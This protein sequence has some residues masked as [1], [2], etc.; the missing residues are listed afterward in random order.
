MRTMIR[1]VLVS[2]LL[3]GFTVAAT[4]AAD[5]TL[6]RNNNSYK[7]FETANLEDVM[8][9]LDAGAN[10]MA[11]TK[12]GITPLHWAAKF[13]DD[14][15][16]IEALLEAGADIGAT[17]VKKDGKNTPLHTAA[18]FNENPEVIQALVAAGA[19]LE[20]RNEW[21]K[22]T[23]LHRAAEY[24]ENPAVVKALI[25][26]GAS[27]E[28]RNEW[29]KH[30]PL[31]RAAE[32]NE[33]PAVVKAL[34]A[35]GASLEAR[36]G[37]NST[38]LHRAARY[39]NNPKVIQALVDAGANPNARNKKGERPMDKAR[40][41]NRRILAAAGGR[42]RT[43][44]GSGGGGLG[45][46]IGVAAA[47]GIGTASG[48]STEAILAGVEAV[49]SSQQTAT[50]G[51]QP[52]AVQNPVGTAGSAAG[53]GSCEILGYPSPP[54]G[55]ANLGFSWCPVSVSMQLRAFALQ[56]A[57]AQCALATGSSSTPA[58]VQ[59]RRR[60]IDAACRRLAALSARGG[61]NCRC[62]P[63]LRP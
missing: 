46:L 20:A 1:S 37:D 34:I 26:A 24:N 21:K 15:E 56:A 30:T 44:G 33:N 43:Q 53:G 40:K 16:I 18:L 50:G 17:T 32:Y 14:P 38:P 61:T 10:P 25:A 63:G 9:C 28:A 42:K 51:G 52:T 49:V 19:S 6:W 13:S 55:M 39:N 7:F 54:G 3:V 4:Q 27:L 11:R 60:E 12:H 2:V 59:A 45:A 36:N 62:P 8:A 5:C 41:R 48:A 47:V 57:G 31:H 23:P 35:A 22:H 29:K 58:Q